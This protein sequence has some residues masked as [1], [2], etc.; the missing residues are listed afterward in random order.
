MPSPLELAA[1]WRLVDHIRDYAV[2]LTA[3]HD[4]C[5]GTDYISDE[6]VLALDLLRGGGTV[7]V[8]E[9]VA[10][11]GM[12]NREAL[13]FMRDLAARGLVA[14]ERAAADRRQRTF[15]FTDAGQE[16]MERAAAEL[17]RYFADAADMADEIAR[18]SET[19]APPEAPTVAAPDTI[20]DSWA[21]AASIARLGQDISRAMAARLG[22][23]REQKIRGRHI[24][25]V[26]LICSNPESRPSTLAADL[27]LSPAGVTYLID[28]LERH[29]FVTRERDLDGDRRGIRVA[30]TAD[31]LA[32]AIAVNDALQDVKPALHARF[33]GHPVLTTA[34]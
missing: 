19:T 5:F 15:Q 14:S 26:L 12:G 22:E 24:I 27:G 13:R 30:L 32:A 34:V 3:V 17:E 7:L 23:E 33:S 9:L 6:Q 28:A 20:A 10:A 16:A 4:G 2:G 25:A 11:T 18:L 8:P 1:S 21:H 31:G 29:G